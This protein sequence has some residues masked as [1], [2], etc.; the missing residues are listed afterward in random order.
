MLK[1]VLA[2]ICCSPWLLANGNELTIIG[3]I[4]SPTKNYNSSN[5]SEYISRLDPDV[6]LTEGDPSMFNSKGKVSN[7]TSGLEVEAYRQLQRHHEIPIVNVS[8]ERR[9]QAMRKIAY[10]QTL[11]QVFQVVQGK[12]KSDDLINASLFEKILETFSARSYC[13]QNSTFEEL[14]SE[15]CVN[16]FQNNSDAIFKDMQTLLE[17]NPNLSDQ[18]ERW[19]PLVAF[20][21]QRHQ[22]MADN[23]VEHLCEGSNKKYLLI[24][25]VLHF[26][27]VKE[28]LSTTDCDFKLRT[29][30][31]EQS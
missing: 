14:Q 30:S 4:H 17:S 18:L 1:R 11:G 5:L 20:H 7:N 21:N 12:Y 8:M 16:A 2:L 29:Y 3:S 27:E 13:M 10:N 25:G 19:K 15:T 28:I 24:V 22:K 9:N 26:S 23:I 6:I 31:D